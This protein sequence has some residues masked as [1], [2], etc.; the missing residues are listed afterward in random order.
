VRGEIEQMQG[1]KRVLADLT[2]L[3]TITINMVEAVEFVAAVEI[4]A[5][6]F[7]SRIVETW[8]DAVG[9]LRNA[10]EA[11]VLL[12]VAAAPWLL[13]LGM[14][15]WLTVRIFRRRRLSTASPS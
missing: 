7:V 12:I 14:P 6:T 15:A 3:T 1:R 4:P 11:V 9:T 2:S 8:T 5:P 13:V 10:A